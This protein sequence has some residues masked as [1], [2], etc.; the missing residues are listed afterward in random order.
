MINPET[1]HLAPVNGVTNLVEFS[2]EEAIRLEGEGEDEWA[3]LY[4]EAAIASEAYH[5]GCECPR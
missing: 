3:D 1:G 4:L 5:A 2:F